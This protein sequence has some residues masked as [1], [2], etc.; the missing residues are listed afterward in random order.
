MLLSE[1]GLSPESCLEIC[2]SRASCGGGEWGKAYEQVVYNKPLAYKHTPTPF[3]SKPL[4]KAI[5]LPSG[6]ADSPHLHQHIDKNLLNFT[7][8]KSQ[9]NKALEPWR[10]EGWS[11][12]GLVISTLCF[13]LKIRKNSVLVYDYR[14]AVHFIIESI[15]VLSGF[16]T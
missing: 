6:Q 2:H 15:V 3:P 7:F 4:S 5:F 10:K 11:S 16:V 9:T 1:R 13:I 12:W 14:F 8:C